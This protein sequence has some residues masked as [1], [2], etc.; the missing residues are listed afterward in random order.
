[1]PASGKYEVRTGDAPEA[2]GPYNQGIALGVPPLLFVSG[3]LGIDPATG[4]L[5]PGGIKAQTA[6]CV[7]NI[8]SIVG[9]AAGGAASIVKT[10]IYLARIEDFP[11]MNEAYGEAIGSPYP[12]RS[13]VGGCDLPRGALVEIEAIAALEG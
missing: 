3:Q 9:A 6:Q 8:R 2:L 13:C 7:S 10:T 1:M 5:A 12:A 4:E 11:A